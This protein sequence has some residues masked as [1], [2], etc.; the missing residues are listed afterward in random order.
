M[1]RLFLT[2]ILALLAI[3][4]Y[5]FLSGT[6]LFK[7]QQEYLQTASN[8]MNNNLLYSKNTTDFIDYRSFAKRP[9]ALPLYVLFNH[10]N[11]YLIRVSQ[12][13]VILLIFF[14]GLLFLRVFTSTK[15][16]FLL[17]GV[18]FSLNFTFLVHSSFVFADLLLSAIVTIA[19]F[20]YFDKRNAEKN[21]SIWLGFLWAIALAI[22]PVLLPSLVFIPFFMGYYLIKKKEI[23]W[24]F[25]FPFLVYF[26]TSSL[27]Y[28]NTGRFEY[29]SMTTINLVQYNARLTIADAFGY[30]SAM[31]FSENK[32]FTIPSSKEE[33]ARYKVEAS[34][35][36]TNAILDNISSYIK[37]HVLGSV[38][39][40][41]DP[42]RFDLYNYFG[43]STENDSVTEEFL[44]GRYNQ[45]LNHLRDGGWLILLFLALLGIS[46][47][48]LAGFLFSIS[49]IRKTWPLFFVVIYFMAV[50][51]PVGAARLFLPVS[52][53][54]LIISILGL[55]KM[56]YFF[57]KRSKR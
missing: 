12:A 14:I 55:E 10:Q 29:S 25:L 22:K 54:F 52:V 46:L 48:K 13:T 9:L 42:G 19:T 36:C 4:I 49:T 3:F 2:L 50:T 44:G 8:L 39:M 47:L 11:I 31:A 56:L 26:F 7:D 16:S 20:L 41:V 35:I 57:Q 32:A 21:K 34:K 43:M 37:I 28:Q 17:F 53:I 40:V 15:R 38:K 5:S 33:Y 23:Y 24:P 51:G 1:K 27:N 6:L 30:D 18:L 45:A